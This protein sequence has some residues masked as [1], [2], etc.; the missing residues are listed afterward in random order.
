MSMDLQALKAQS[1]GAHPSRGT[2]LLALAAIAVALVVAA[3]SSM[4][5]LAGSGNLND[6]VLLTV[7]TGTLAAS[8]LTTSGGTPVA[9]PTA[10]SV[11][12]GNS[13]VDTFMLHAW[14]TTPYYGGTSSQTSIS[15]HGTTYQIG[16]L[17]WFQQATVSGA[18]TTTTSQYFSP[19][20]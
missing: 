1:N 5:T 3:P 14:A 8:T 18:G 17:M 19:L 9:S 20:L 10:F 12:N 16:D 4:G 7:A 2:R 15:I 11:N 6:S 13:N